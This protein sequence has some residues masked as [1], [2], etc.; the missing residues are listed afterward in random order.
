LIKDRGP[1]KHKILYQDKKVWLRAL[2]S[3]KAKHEWWID[4]E[5]KLETE[6]NEKTFESFALVVTYKCG[7]LGDI[8]ATNVLIKG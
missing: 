4:S 2:V 8:P 5:S 6:Q 3:S 1:I 7:S